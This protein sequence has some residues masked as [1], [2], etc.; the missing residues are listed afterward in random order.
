MVH[1]GSACGSADMNLGGAAASAARAAL[2][3]EIDAWH[4]EIAVIDGELSDELHREPW[5]AFGHSVDGALVRAAL[6]GHRSGRTMGDD[7][8]DED[9]A[10]AAG[11]IAADAAGPPPRR[12]GS[13]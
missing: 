5:T 1:P 3:S 6:D 4:G 7:G 13:P 9:Q 12:G 8:S 10:H 2:A 11:L